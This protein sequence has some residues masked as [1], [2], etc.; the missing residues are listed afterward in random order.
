[1]ATNDATLVR[2][3]GSSIVC[4]RSKALEEPVSADRRISMSVLHRFLKSITDALPN[5][6]LILLSCSRFHTLLPQSCG[7]GGQTLR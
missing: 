2:F 3:G 1:M 4:H 5:S 6:Y 7:A